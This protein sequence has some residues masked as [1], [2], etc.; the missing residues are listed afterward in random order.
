T[1]ASTQTSKFC[2]IR[3][4]TRI[5]G[6]SESATNS[7]PWTVS[8]NYN[9]KHICGGTLINE[10]WVLT[11]AHCFPNLA[12]S[13][14]RI[15]LG[16]NNISNWGFNGTR[17]AVS[18]IILHESYTAS[19]SFDI[20]LIKLKN[21]IIFTNKIFPACIPSTYD[22]FERKRCFFA[23]WGRTYSDGPVQEILRELSQLVLSESECSVHVKKEIEQKYC[24]GYPKSPE[25]TCQVEKDNSYE[26]DSGAGMLCEKEDGKWY[27]AGI[28][29]YGLGSCNDIGVNARRLEKWLRNSM[30][31]DRV[32]DLAI[33]LKEENEDVDLVVI[34]EN[35]SSV[36]KI[37]DFR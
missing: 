5:V 23:G 11:A 31:Q 33:L 34:V 25:D 13:A 17:S 15:I 22:N 16:T 35:F 27:V 36:E 6:G 24:T 8:L 37:S 10:Q 21:P 32:S 4:K 28:V 7:W 3:F 1:L 14:Y 18:K 29:S 30:A 12:T 19:R 26:G 2:G 9:F 20:A